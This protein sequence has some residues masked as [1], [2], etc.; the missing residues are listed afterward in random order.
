MRKLILLIISV[1]VLSGL[2]YGIYIKYQVSVSA[3]SQDTPWSTAG[4]NPQRTSWISEEPSAGNLDELWVRPIVPYIPQKVQ[5]VGAEGKVY[6]STSR[7]LYAYDAE[8]GSEKWVF[9]TELPL[10]HS[11]TYANGVLYVGGLDRKVYAV[12]ASNGNKIWEFA[13]D[14]GFETSP[15]FAENKIFIGSRDKHMYALNTNGSLAWKYKTGGQILHSAAYANGKIYFGSNDGHAYA[16]NTNGSLAWKTKLPTMGW[17]SWWPV[18]YK[19]KVIF[20]KT[21]YERNTSTDFSGDSNI[22]LENEWLFTNPDRS[23]Y[24]A[25]TLGTESGDW[26]NGTIT[27]DLRNNPLGKSILDYYEENRDTRTVFVLNQA[28][29]SEENYDLDNDG[30][31]DAAPIARATQ[32]HGTI[33]PPVVSGF[34]QVPYFRNMIMVNTS[35]FASTV[36]VGWKVGTPHI[37]LPFSRMSQQS[38]HFPADEPAGISGAGRYVYWN[39]CC[40]RFIGA[41]DISKPNTT[42][43]SLDNTRQWRFVH[44]V[45]N[46]PA[47]SMPSGYEKEHY[48]FIWDFSNGQ[49]GV[50]YYEHGDNVGPAIYKG[51]MYVIRSNALV[52]FGVG[53]AGSNAPVLSSSS[54]KNPV[55]SSNIIPESTLKSILAEEVQKMIATGHLKPGYGISGSL[56]SPQRNWLGDNLLDYWH[57]PGDTIYILLKALPYLPSNLQSQ[58]KSY[59]QSE[60]NQFPPY[61]YSHIGWKDGKFREGFDFLPLTYEKIKNLGPSTNSSFKGYVIPPQNFYAM[62]KYAEAGLGDP[63]QIFAAAKSKLKSTTPMSDADLQSFPHAFNAYITGYKGYIEL[64]KLAGEPSSS[65]S[66]HQA[67]LNRL[68]NLRA[69]TFTY[70]LRPNTGNS[71]GDRYFWS[72]VTAYNFMELSPELSNHLR[73]NALPKVQEAVNKYESI[74]PLWFVGQNRE[75]QGE[76]GMTAYQQTHALFQAKAQILNASREEL[77][78]YLDSPVYPVGDLYYIDNVVAAIEAKPSDPNATPVPTQAPSSTPSI[79]GDANGDEIVDGLDYVVWLVNYDTNTTAGSSKGDFDGNGKVD[80]IDYVIWLNNYVIDSPNPTPVVTSSP[81]SDN[82]KL[83]ASSGH[84][85]SA[86]ATLPS[87]EK[88]TSMIDE[89]I[90]EAKTSYGQGVPKIILVNNNIGSWNEVVQ[91]IEAA[92]GSGIPLAG[93]GTN[94][95]NYNSLTREQFVP[96][97][98]RS[99]SIFA[100]GGTN[101]ENVQVVSTSIRNSNNVVD[102]LGAGKNL[103]NLLVPHIDKNKK[104]LIHLFGPGHYD[105][106]SLT[107]LGILPELKQSF[108][109]PVPDSIKIIGSGAYINGGSLTN[110]NFNSGTITAVLVQGSFSIATRGIGETF[111]SEGDVNASKRI[112]QETVSEL[113]GS[114]EVLF[115]V[116]GHPDQSRYSQV[117]DAVTSV[118]DNNTVIFGHEGGGEIGHCAKGVSCG[119]VLKDGSNGFLGTTNGQAVSG[120][121][122][123]F[124][125]GLKSN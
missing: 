43:P 10:G 121:M 94:S 106:N 7:G 70:D 13:A 50:W 101:I 86:G 58:L 23:G 26:V 42:F 81:S 72:L 89:A 114:P 79:P 49:H 47:P 92:F 69:Q 54:I 11:P 91:K 107:L 109:D 82:P 115:Y 105:D 40:D 19:D 4:A 16:L 45:G 62:W 24:V 9:P 76:G 46:P 52:A 100:F 87:S 1:F 124:V 116:P 64:A 68:L 22:Y 60:F 14:G 29:G 37:S 61:T 48:K 118:L 120:K 102:Y 90:N 125:A 5:V 32:D 75:Q 35:T 57:N 77:V 71:V 36:P 93:A 97:D 104:N 3:Q 112:V 84:A 15:L 33:Y 83:K 30:R 95:T 2:I 12:N 99:I 25:G 98:N 17:Y 38:G 53:G 103:A 67:E 41:V 20:T 55:T 6:V 123:M 122:H 66:A 88:I 34:D 63:K 18:V 119:S 65:Y 113:G 27:A 51:K 110:K 59:I 39:L 96:H 31:P 8:N 28:S 78:K 74:A 44:G 85:V 108:G 117:R 56:D 73:T 21:E 111:G 80:G